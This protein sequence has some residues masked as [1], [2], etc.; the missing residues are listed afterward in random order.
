MAT[1]VGE[2]Q[3]SPTQEHIIDLND[4]TPLVPQKHCCD[5]FLQD[6]PCICAKTVYDGMGR[7]L[8]GRVCRIPATALVFATSSI[9][10]CV[11][12][13]LEDLPCK[14]G[15]LTLPCNIM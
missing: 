5:T 11:G 3:F 4:E 1:A 15:H 8:C 12:N 2:V 10:Y 13:V 14:K 7:S 6:G 9:V